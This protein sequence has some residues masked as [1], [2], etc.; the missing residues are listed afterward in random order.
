MFSLA[1]P[2]LAEETAEVPIEFMRNALWYRESYYIMKDL[3]ESRTETIKQR[4]EQIF[5][6]QD[7]VSSKDSQLRVWRT[8]A[9]GAV[10][11]I[12]VERLFNMVV[13]R[14]RE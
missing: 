2:V 13:R 10:G 11:F 14:I 7:E 12:V 3:A 9:I 8:V 1:S 5:S 4:E 6:L